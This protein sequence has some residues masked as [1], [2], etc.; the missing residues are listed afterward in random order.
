MIEKLLEPPLV[1]ILIA[2][3]ALIVL[4]P[5]YKLLKPKEK[6]AQMIAVKCRNCGWTGKVGKYNKTCSKCGS[7]TLAPR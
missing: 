3:G 6:A 7:S 5:I 1:Y 2:V 4:P